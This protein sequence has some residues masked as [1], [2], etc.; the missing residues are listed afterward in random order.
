MDFLLDPAFLALIGTLFGAV[1]LKSFENFVSKAKEVEGK[2]A[3][4]SLPKGD[5]TEFDCAVYDTHIFEQKLFE[6][7]VLSRKDITLCDNE[8]CPLCKPE[9]TYRALDAKRVWEREEMASDPEGWKRFQELKRTDKRWEGYTF[10]DYM[11]QM[12]IKHQ[13]EKELA[14]NRARGGNC[15]ACGAW[16]ASIDQQRCFTC[17][18]Q[19][20]AK[21]YKELASNRMPIVLSGET[22]IEPIRPAEVPEYAYYKDEQNLNGFVRRLWSWTDRETGKTMG[23]QQVITDQSFVHSFRTV[24]RPVSPIKLRKPIYNGDMGPN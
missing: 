16:L 14:A 19:E 10:S 22:T 8:D 3:P 6:G 18:A 20:Q 4:L 5:L 7:G 9:R 24:E 12:K 15:E 11:F 21:E 23:L 1:A 17:K 2:Q 13:R